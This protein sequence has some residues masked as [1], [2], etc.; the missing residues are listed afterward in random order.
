MG[1]LRHPHPRQHLQPPYHKLPVSAYRICE[2]C[3][4]LLL[5]QSHARADHLPGNTSF[6]DYWGSLGSRCFPSRVRAP[7]E[8]WP[9]P[10]QQ[11]GADSRASLPAGRREHSLPGAG[12]MKRWLNEW[13]N[14]WVSS[15]A[16]PAALIFSFLL[17]WRGAGSGLFNVLGYLKMMSWWHK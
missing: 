15:F 2:N 17:C 13:T 3:C 10:R 8:E 9:G 1:R 6:C 14:Q 11:R 7:G 5:A 12:W 16:F 4:Q